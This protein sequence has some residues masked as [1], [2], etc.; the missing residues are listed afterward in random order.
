MSDHRTVFGTVERQYW[1]DAAG[2]KPD[3]RALI[4]RYLDPAGSTLEAGSGGGRILGEM[5]KMGFTS[6]RG[7]D[8]VPE[9]VA[10]ARSA[11]ADE[12]IEFDVDDATRLSYP[13][14]SFDQVF[15][16]QHLLSTLERA[17]ARALVVREAH[18]ILRPG[19]V[20]LFSALPYEVRS[21]SR[22]GR[23]YVAYLRAL[24]R[25]RRTDRPDRLLPR[26]RRRGRPTPAALL[27]SGPHVYWYGAGELQGELEAAGFGIEAIGTTPQVIAGSMAPDASRLEA[28]PL[29]GAMYAVAKRRA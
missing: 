20:A 21:R 11:H 6:L 5:R 13:D 14:Q 29:A 25:L 7:F 3:E 22:A 15:Y 16:L 17:D 24:R 19:G 2:L 26:M 9:L 12:G 10:E 23:L 18:R 4:E 27:D 28:A 8:F 1:T